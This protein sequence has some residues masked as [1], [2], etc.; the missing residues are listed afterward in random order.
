MKPLN[1]FLALCAMLPM[2][3]C[4]D[5]D[6]YE[7]SALP[8]TFTVSASDLT[9]L[10]T[11]HT[12]TV[13]VQA[14]SQPSVSTDASWLTV[15]TPVLNDQSKRIYRFDVTAAANDTHDTRT[16]AITVTQASNKAT[17]N[18]TQRY[19]DGI[20][21]DA[22]S[23]TDP[24]SANG[25][26]L[27]V[28]I[29]ATGEYT[30]ELPYWVTEETVSGSRAMASTTHTFTIAANNGNARTADIV[31]TLV[32]DET[33]SATVTI[34]QLLSQASTGKTAAAVASQIFAGWNLG[35]TMEATGGSET[36]WGNVKTSKEIIDVVKAAG[37]NAVRIPCSW[38]QYIIDDN[39]TIDPVWLSRV[40]EVI[41]YV[42]NDDMYAVLNIHWDGGWLEENAN[43]SAQAE[44]VAKQKALWT[45]IA[46]AFEGY[47]DHLLFAGCNE[48][49]NTSGS[50]WNGPTAEEEAALEAYLQAFIDAVRATGGNNAER[51]L[52]VQ[53]WCCNG[54]RA[55]DSL[56]M[57]TDPA[58]SDHLMME[59]HFYDPS[60]MTHEGST[61]KWGYRAGYVSSN[62]GL[63]ED[64]IDSFFG[65]IKAKY[66][67][68]GIPVILGEYG[69]CCWS[70]TDADVMASQAY[71]LRYVTAA[72][73]NNGMVPFYWD[74][75]T[76]GI[77]S[78]GVINRGAL[79]VGLPHFVEGIMAGA[80]EGIYPF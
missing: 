65:Q 79:A 30:Y 24:F 63:Q 45:Q 68:K 53:C 34:S 48:V 44:N 76:P 64:Y 3:A 67:D 39:Y 25:G 78:F 73:K 33:L 72:A 11:E 66:V 26:T 77:G 55:L 46:N 50:G 51:N 37:F 18:V 16:A 47:D 9:Y 13:Y 32:D 10:K 38:D 5:D 42:V 49:R 8:T 40:G 59:M 28:S 80:A 7:P 14:P 58:G 23:T 15:T 22:V 17:I 75:G 70:T 20:L 74:N 1:I 62:D 12:I 36:S 35:N 21:V 27:T 56:T 41:D 6:T 2:T 54:W 43:A 31:F 71:Y 57:P 29:Q 4:S 69:T 52:I 60:A 19:A 61:T